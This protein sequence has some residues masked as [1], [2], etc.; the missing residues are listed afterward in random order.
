MPPIDEE[1]EKYRQ[2]KEIFNCRAMV[3]II[4]KESETYKQRQES[5]CGNNEFEGKK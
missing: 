2:R 1:G 4:Q 5:C 3:T